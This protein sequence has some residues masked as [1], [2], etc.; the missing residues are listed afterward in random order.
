M[1]KR[2]D[3]ATQIV[4][5]LKTVRAVKSVTREPKRIDELS[6]ASFPHV[7]VES[8]NEIRDVSSF[9]QTVRHQADIDFLINIV[10]MGKDRDSQRNNILAAIEETLQAD[11]TL[12]GLV[13]DSYVTQIQIREIEEAEPMATAAMIYTV[14]YYY[15]RGQ[16]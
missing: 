14:R 7:L 4:K 16:P 15:D 8:A 5:S 13:H 9:G 11:A 10:V 1:S 2:E 12:A 6:R 3:I